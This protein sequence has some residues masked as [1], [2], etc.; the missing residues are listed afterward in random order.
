M[1][2]VIKKINGTSSITLPP[3]SMTVVN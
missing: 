1:P 3:F 2:P